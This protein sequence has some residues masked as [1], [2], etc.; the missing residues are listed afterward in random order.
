MLQQLQEA[1]G[2]VTTPQAKKPPQGQLWNSHLYTENTHI[3]Y[4]FPPW[5]MSSQLQGAQLSECAR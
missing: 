2:D 3:I 5:G 1:P 4:L